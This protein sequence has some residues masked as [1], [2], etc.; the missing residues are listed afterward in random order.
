M[1]SRPRRYADYVRGLA[2]TRPGETPL[3]P[4]QWWRDIGYRRYLAGLARRGSGE[5][6][7][8]RDEWWE[9]FGRRPPRNPAGGPGDPEHQAVVADL[10]ARA[11]T[12]YPPPRYRVMSNQRVPTPSGYRKPDV[13]VIDT[14][15]GRVVRV[16]EAARFN[17]A[18]GF[19]QAYEAPKILDYEALGIPYEFHP[20]G[21]NRPPGGILTTRPPAP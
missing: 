3:T 16:Y 7:L 17:A 8:S 1:G 20:V 2:R 6:P 5:R 4:E 18:G 11:E 21:P 13:A 12:A 10:R 9:Q 19:E 14:H 15:T